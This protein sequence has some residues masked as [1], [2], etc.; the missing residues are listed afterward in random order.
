MKH[1]DRSL[2]MM[3][4]RTLDAVMPSFRKV[5]SEHGLT[6]QQWR[7]LRVLWE[8]PEMSLVA[9]SGKTLISP[10]SLVGIID[11]LQRDGLVERVRSTEDRR[12]INIRTTEAGKKLE[13]EVSP[14]VDAIYQS[15]EAGID[16]TLW[17]SLFFALDQLVAAQQGGQPEDDAANF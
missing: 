13:R 10:P 7:I 11:R 2:P 5:F 15:I 6:E 17:K 8:V 9:I 16:P 3:L 1:F 4:Y 14:K 12:V